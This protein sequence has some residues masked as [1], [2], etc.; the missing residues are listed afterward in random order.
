[1]C[2][3]AGNNS[4]CKFVPVAGGRYGSWAGGV[5]G[6]PSNH[7]LV[8]YYINTVLFFARP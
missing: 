6:G 8:Q 4:I 7:Q 3:Y 2:G 5:G 1:M